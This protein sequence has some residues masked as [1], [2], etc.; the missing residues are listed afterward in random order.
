MAMDGPQWSH[1]SRTQSR[2]LRWKTETH[3]L[4]PSP[5]NS[6][7]LN[8]Q[9]AGLEAKVELDFKPRHSD[10]ACL[11]PHLWL[12]AL[13]RNTHPRENFK[14]TTIFYVGQ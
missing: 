8:Q 5:A 1:E 9:E 11:C 12:N 10:K 13:Y 2:S 14:N 6:Q 3:I 7:D 4:E